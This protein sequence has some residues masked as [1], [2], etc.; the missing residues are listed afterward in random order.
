MIKGYQDEQEAK[1]KSDEE[2]YEKLLHGSGKMLLLDKF[3]N[4]FKESGHKMLIFS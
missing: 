4:K 1:C 3:I 2:L